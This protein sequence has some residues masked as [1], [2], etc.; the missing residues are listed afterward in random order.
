M[1]NCPPSFSCVPDFIGSSVCDEIEL[2]FDSAKWVHGGIGPFG[3]LREERRRCRSAPLGRSAGSRWLYETIFDLVQAQNELRFHFEIDGISECIQLLE[4]REG[5]CF[6]WHQDLDPGM[7][8]KRKI[9]VSIQLTPPEDYEGGELLFPMPCPGILRSDLDDLLANAR[10]TA[11]L[12]PSYQLHSVGLVRRGM[13]RA[14]VAWVSGP[15]FR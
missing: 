1:P 15:V 12:F 3:A 7:A 5:D 13:R 9:S 6:D 10:G 11:I 14:L 2:L 4:Y 8:A